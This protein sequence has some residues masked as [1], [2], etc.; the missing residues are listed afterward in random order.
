M[1]RIT[2]ILMLLFSAS[3][4]LAQKADQRI[5]QLLNTSD[6]FGLQEELLLYGD[7]IQTP[8]LKQTAEAILSFHQNRPHQTVK[9]VDQLLEKHQDELGVTNLIQLLTIKFIALRSLGAY[10]QIDKELSKVLFEFKQQHVTTDI[11]A[12]QTIY[13]NNKYH[14]NYQPLSISRP[15]HDVTVQMILNTIMKKEKQD[16]FRPVQLDNNDLMTIPIVVHG[17]FY[18]FI[19]DTGATSTLVSQRMA[20]EMGV[21]LLNNATV[22]NGNMQIK[23]GYLDSLQVGDITIR[24]TILWVGIPSQTDSIFTFDS[25]LGLDCIKA[26][27]ESQID[28][29]NRKIVFPAQ[30]TP[31]PRTGSNLLIDNVPIFKAYQGKQQLDFKLDTG[32]TGAQL[33]QKYYHNHKAEVDTK[34]LVQTTIKGSYHQILSTKV[35]LMPLISFDVGFR[36]FTISP[37]SVLLE[38]TTPVIHGD[39]VM[40]MDLIKLTQKAILN[41]NDMFLKLE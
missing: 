22:V 13:D 8:N 24:H 9:L 4:L 16:L 40:G 41:F 5:E 31:L 35:A 20:Q 3:T 30:P 12:L 27:G 32:D 29:P 14:L 10:Q 26:I 1:Q 39:G 18:P 33:S 36:K 2:I 11:S 25:I 7:S 19:F 38:Q 28:Y 34:G 17:K 37:I 6:W 23:E 21:K 15:A